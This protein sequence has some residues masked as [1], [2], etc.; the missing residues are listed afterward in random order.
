MKANPFA[1]FAAGSNAN[2]DDNGG[3][4]TTRKPGRDDKQIKKAADVA[5]EARKNKNSRGKKANNNNNTKGKKGLKSGGKRVG[6]KTKQ[7]GR[8][9]SWLAESS[10]EE[11][12]EY[13]DDTVTEDEDEWNEDESSEEEIEMLDEDSDDDFQHSNTNSRSK[14]SKAAGRNKRNATRKNTKES[15]INIDDTTDDEIK[16]VDT[17]IDDI[18]DDDDEKESYIRNKDK[19]QAAKKSPYFLEEKK[20][21]DDDNT[22]RSDESFGMENYVSKNKATN[23]RRRMILLDGDDD[24]SDDDMGKVDKKHSSMKLATARSSGNDTDEDILADTPAKS[25]KTQNQSY[26]SDDFVDD[27]E[28]KA[29]ERAMKNSLKDAKKRKRLKKMGGRGDSLAS[30]DDRQQEKKKKKIIYKDDLEDESIIDVDDLGDDGQDEDEDDIYEI[31]NEEEQTASE[32]L[33]EANA[34]SAKIIKIVSGWCG[35]QAGKVQGLILGDSDGALNLG[36]GTG[37]NEHDESWISKETMK[38]IMPGVE[39]AEY[40]LLGVNWM[41]LLN[42]TT[43]GSNSKCSSSKKRPDDRNRGMTT[44]G[45]L[46]D[47][48]RLYFPPIFLLYSSFLSLCSQL[49]SLS[50]YVSCLL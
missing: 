46:A 3:W 11:F 44:N 12:V 36:G 35:G 16:G 23:K 50:L 41:A 5:R 22:S 6:N 1:D 43:F 30:L 17:S 25:A 39:L 32:V 21:D 10:E 8:D 4:M 13:D 20:D 29:I 24:S 31:V 18:F 7:R 38:Q 42:R 34:L 33:K 40:Q 28:A 19:K 9:E 48:V 26:S 37:G 14:T 49:T 2:G 45:I 15:V 47:E 27:E